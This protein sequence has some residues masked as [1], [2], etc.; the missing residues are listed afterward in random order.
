MRKDL[1]VVWPD[2]ANT[3][4]FIPHQLILQPSDTTTWTVTFRK[5]SPATL[6]TSLRFSVGDQLTNWQKLEKVIV[7]GYTVSVV[8]FIMEMNL[9]VTNRRGRKFTRVRNIP[10]IHTRLH[11]R[12]HPDKDNSCSGKVDTERTHK[13]RI[14]GKNEVQGGQIQISCNEEGQGHRQ[15]CTQSAERRHPIHSEQSNQVFGQMVWTKTASGGLRNRL[16]TVW[17]K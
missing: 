16:R 4:G 13:R 17:R 8:L 10:A 11:G 7:T 3:C 5:S 2:L 6:K 9:L 14:M 15:I 1:T 12:P